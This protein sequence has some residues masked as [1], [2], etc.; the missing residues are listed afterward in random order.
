MKHTNIHDEERLYRQML[1]ELGPNAELYDN[2]VARGMHPAARLVG[3]ASETKENKLRRIG[4]WYAAC[5]VIAVMGITLFLLS[6]H[7]ESESQQMSAVTSQSVSTPPV[8]RANETLRRE[9]SSGQQSSAV[10]MMSMRKSSSLLV[11]ADVHVESHEHIAA[12][13]SVEELPP[14]PSSK[15]QSL[16]PSSEEH[17]TR[18]SIPSTSSCVEPE[19]DSVLI[20]GT[21][22]AELLTAMLSEIEE[23][24]KESQQK[25]QHLYRSVIEGVVT[26]I[27]EQ[28]DQPELIL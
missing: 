11:Q 22:D 26:N 7:E 13:S 23:R 5:I 4:Y 25:E 24:V 12:T 2:I 17:A 18:A 14:S 15:N 28:S 16:S 27:I 1:E 20:D 19:A 6:G 8:R 10:V 3:A 9:I 21:S